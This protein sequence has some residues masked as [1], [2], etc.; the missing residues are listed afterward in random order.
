MSLSNKYNIPQSTVN[1][2]VKDGVISCTWPRYEEVYDMYKS[3]SSSGKTKTEIY[4]EIAERTRISEHTV[5][6]I[7]LKMDKI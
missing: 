1:K 3:Y 6:M 5:K 4:Y 2:M 7:V